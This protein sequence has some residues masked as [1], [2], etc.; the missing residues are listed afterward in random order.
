MTLAALGDLGDAQQLLL[1]PARDRKEIT[2]L[3]GMKQGIGLTLRPFLSGRA[4]L[5][6][7]GLEVKPGLD[8]YLRLTP[9]TTMSVIR[10]LPLT[11]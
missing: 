3:E 6:D 11:R 1:R 7:G 5:D 9:S 10:L 8:L 4:D 2:G